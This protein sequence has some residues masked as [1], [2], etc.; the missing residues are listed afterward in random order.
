MADTNELRRFLRRHPQPHA[1]LCYSAEGEDPRTV[2]LGVSRSKFRDAEE[3]C[4]PYPIL[5][6]VDSDGAVLRRFE[7]EGDGSTSN[8]KT[9]AVHFDPESQ[10]LQHFATLLAEAHQSVYKAFEQQATIMAQL[11]AR[12]AAL[13][14]ARQKELDAWQRALNQAGT[15]EGEDMSDKLVQILATVAPALMPML[16][17]KAEANGKK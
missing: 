17:G 7:R 5:E 13:E 15:G 4:D 6:A 11:A 9:K 3:A 10:R 8:G 14:S 2:K 12:N 16:A 1:V